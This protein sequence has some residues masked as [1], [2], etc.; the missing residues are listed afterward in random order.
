MWEELLAAN[1]RYAGSFQGGHLPAQPSRR[2]GVLTCMDARLDPLAM[3]GLR[4]GEANVIRGAGSRAT[5]DV[6]SSLDMAAD[7]FG[8]THIAVIHH[9]NCAAVRPDETHLLGVDV[10]AVRERLPS[11]DVAGLRYDVETGRLSREV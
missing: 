2:L 6:V 4:I 8:L 5:A 10:A 11:V 7:V 9:T 3:L 1:E